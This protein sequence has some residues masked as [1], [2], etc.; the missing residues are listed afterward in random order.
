[1]ARRFRELIREV[2]ELVAELRRL[3]R[4]RGRPGPLDLRVALLD[5]LLARALRDG[6]H[7][8]P[9][10]LGGEGLLAV[11]AAAGRHA[12]D[13]DVDAALVGPE[14]AGRRLQ[15]PSALRTLHDPDSI[16]GGR[17]G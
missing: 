2:L 17:T 4:D 11:L 13:H 9:R 15:L 8:P 5:G 16:S 6:V 3:Q 14:I 12:G 7:A 1:G 10:A